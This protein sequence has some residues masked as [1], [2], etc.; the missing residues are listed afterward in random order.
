MA[1]YH[2]PTVIQPFIPLC[3][4]SP[5]EHLLLGQMLQSEAGGAKGDCLY[6]F[7]ELSPETYVTVNAGELRAAYQA[8]LDFESQILPAAKLW[9]DKI[10]DLDDDAETAFDFIFDVNLPYPAYQILLQDIVQRSATVNYFTIEG[11]YTC[12]KMRPDGFGGIAG[13]VHAKGIKVQGTSELI[14]RFILEA[15]FSD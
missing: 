13:I 1:D 5:L 10:R 12:T 3:E 8:S 15:G 9:I 2:S 11:A 7:A 4:M 6:F 14:E